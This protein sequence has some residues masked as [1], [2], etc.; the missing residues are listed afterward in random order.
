MFD[1]SIVE[2]DPAFVVRAHQ[3]ELVVGDL[4]LEKLI[5]T[6]LVEDMFAP[7]Q[8]HKLL[9]IEPH[10]TNLTHN[11]IILIVPVGH[12]QFFLLF[13]QLASECFRLLVCLLNFVKVFVVVLLCLV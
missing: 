8:R 12:R 3:R 7:L 5:E 4:H 10:E 1:V 6:V 11:L 2:V 9:I 13:L